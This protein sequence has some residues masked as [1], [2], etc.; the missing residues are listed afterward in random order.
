[1]Q[2]LKIVDIGCQQKI[3]YAWEF[4]A[5]ERFLIDTLR[6]WRL[7]LGEFTKPVPVLCSNYIMLLKNKRAE[8]CRYFWW[9]LTCIFRGKLNLALSLHCIGGK[10]KSFAIETWWEQ[11]L[12]WWFKHSESLPV[13]VSAHCNSN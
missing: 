7:Q 4:R 10:N 11:G 2:L 3:L 8:T 1:M 13:P 6:D 9:N 12:K 5:H